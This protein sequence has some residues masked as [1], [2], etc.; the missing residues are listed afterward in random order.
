[1][2]PDHIRKIKPARGRRFFLAIAGTVLIAVQ[3]FGV[4]QV[5]GSQVRKAQL[6]DVQL[7][8]QRVAIESCMETRPGVDIGSCLRH[9]PQDPA[10][11]DQGSVS[12]TALMR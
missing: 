1:M 2:F 12:L 3:L 4:A 10:G 7:Q 11:S 6:R 8:L 5:A 9:G